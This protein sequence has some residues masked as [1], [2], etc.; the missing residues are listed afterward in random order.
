MP[1]TSEL[2]SSF[3]SFSGPEQATHFARAMV[4]RAAP[5][6]PSRAKVLLFAVARLA[7]FAISVGLETNPEVIFHPCVIERFIA[8][9]TDDFSSATRRTLRSNLR[10]VALR[11]VRSGSPAAMPLSREHAKAPYSDAEIAAYL[12]LSRSQPTLAR[13]MHGVGLICLGAGAGLMGADLRH[14]TGHDVVCRSGGVLVCVGGKRPRMVPVLASYHE[15]LVESSRFAADRYVIGGENPQR[16]NVTTPLVSAT[17]GG[18]DLGRLDIG[19]LRSTWLSAC[20]KN[21]GLATFMAAAGISCSQ[22]LGDIVADLPVADE[23]A[24]VALLGARP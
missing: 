12:A 14:V 8:C 6:S 11:V 22:R 19:R 9:G 16:R 24:A 20:A 4:R 10:F 3:G 13:R 21:I 1:T 5:S 23:A 7:S 2:I 15:A 18:I 17:S